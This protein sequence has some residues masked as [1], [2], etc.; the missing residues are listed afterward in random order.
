M[1]TADVKGWIQE[2]FPLQQVQFKV[3][4]FQT[5]CADRQMWEVHVDGKMFVRG[6]LRD[7]RQP[8]TRIFK[9][10]LGKRS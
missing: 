2:T 5:G 8:R 10:F 7:F 1:Y 4:R 3:S 6:V 9:L